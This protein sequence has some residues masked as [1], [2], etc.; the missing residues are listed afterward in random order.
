VSA[1]LKA[2]EESCSLLEALTLA[3]CAAF[4]DEHGGVCYL[5]EILEFIERATA[6][7][8]HDT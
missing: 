2:F 1:D 5:A 4:P 8:R 3:R 7:S 6:R